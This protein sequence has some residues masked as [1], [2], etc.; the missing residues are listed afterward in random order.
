MEILKVAHLD[1]FSLIREYEY[2]DL[3]EKDLLEFVKDT[4]PIIQDNRN[5]ND[6]YKSSVYGEFAATPAKFKFLPGQK[7][8]IRKIYKESSLRKT[9][10]TLMS[11][12]PKKQKHIIPEKGIETLELELR[13]NMRNFWITLKSKTKYESDD[14]E[15]ELTVEKDDD[16]HIATLKCI[17]CGKKVSIR[18]KCNNPWLTNY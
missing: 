11:S 2:V 15:M 13:N 6:E 9:Q 7:M 8:I 14:N 1:C 5:W 10:A 17:V 12:Q 18:K 3:F 4:I 16:D